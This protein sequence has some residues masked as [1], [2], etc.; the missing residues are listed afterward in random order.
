MQTVALVIVTASG[1]WLVAV[2][3]LMAL[4]PSYGLELF[5]KM[6]SSLT[7]SNWRLQFTEQG[8]RILAGAA[9]IIRSH[10]SKL[11]YEALCCGRCGASLF[12]LC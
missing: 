12:L 6:T 7:A 10:L 11:P 4:R 2:S 1:L 5:E 8:L 9:L 3:F